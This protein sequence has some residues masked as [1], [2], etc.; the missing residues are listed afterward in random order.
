MTSSPGFT[1]VTIAS[2]S[3]GH[4]VSITDATGTH[5]FDV[6]NGTNGTDGEN[7]VTFTPVVSA[8]GVISWTNNGGLPNPESVNIKGAPGRDGTDGTDGVSPAVSI[9][10]IA[11]GH[12][13][14]I[15]D[16][17]HPDGQAFDVMDGTN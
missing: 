14:T 17:E 13:V 9:S 5:E 2:I 3:G 1:R 15:T 8:E 4:R 6:L 10:E 7:G 11:G 12:E 16:A